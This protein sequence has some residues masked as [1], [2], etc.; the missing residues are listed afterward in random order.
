MAHTHEGYRRVILAF[1]ER[2]AR[3]QSNKAVCNEVR[4]LF[5]DVQMSI[6]SEV[7]GQLMRERQV[8]RHGE[9][10]NRRCYWELERHARLRPVSSTPEPV[11]VVGEDEPEEDEPEEVVVDK[12]RAVAATSAPADPHQQFAMQVAVLAHQLTEAVAMQRYAELE[13]DKRA[14][15]A[16]VARLQAELQAAEALLDGERAERAQLMAWLQQSPLGDLLRPRGT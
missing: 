14:L 16:E 6:F 2:S 11:F 13:R 3:A 8:V 10:G 9:D 5:D 7:M 15:E 1:L 4:R 12:P